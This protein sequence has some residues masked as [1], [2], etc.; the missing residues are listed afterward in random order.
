MIRIRGFTLVELLVVVSIIGIL[1]S[2]V[3]IN[4]NS[5]R[6]QSRDSRRKSDI[7]NVAGALELYYADHHAYPTAVTYGQSLR[8]VLNVYSSNIASDPSGGVSSDGVFGTGYFYASNGSHFL[9]DVQLE[10]PEAATTTVASP[11]SSDNTFVTGTYTDS[12]NSSTHYR[13][14]GP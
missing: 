2:V 5:A 12:S 3:A 7:Q 6:R 9:L 14:S 1:A 11:G 4:A 8:A 13:V 10:R